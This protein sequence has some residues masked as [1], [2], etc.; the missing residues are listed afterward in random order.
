L[1]GGLA[2]P[3]RA[4]RMVREHLL[5]PKEFWTAMPVPTV[6]VS[7]RS[8]GPDMWRGPVWHCYNHLVLDG[9]LRYGFRKEA[10]ELIRRTVEATVDWY[11]RTGSIWEFYDPASKAEPKALDRKGPKRGAIAEYSWSA[12]ELLHF[13]GLSRRGLDAIAPGQAEDGP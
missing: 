4:E 13:L 2:T 5:N 7:D 6:S 11:G 12:A 3:E 8:Y 1:F 10:E 9:L